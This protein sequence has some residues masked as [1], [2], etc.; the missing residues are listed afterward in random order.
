VISFSRI[1]G[2]EPYSLFQDYYFEA[3]RKKQNNIEAIAISSYQKDIEEVDSRFVNLKYIEE[4][5][6]FFYTNY[7]SPKAKQFAQSEKISALIFWN[8][9]NTQIRIKA[10]IEKQS[11]NLNQKYFENRN[12]KKNALAISSRQSRSIESFERIVKNFE[13]TLKNADLAEC[14]AYWGGYYFIPYYFE[15]WEGNENRLNKRIA[16]EK[17]GHRWKESLKQP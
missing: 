13:N 8:S 15:F 3:E 10:K 7:N 5:R 17:N 1:D 2:T 12:P 6:W 16:F 11:H 14:P 9:I 4:N